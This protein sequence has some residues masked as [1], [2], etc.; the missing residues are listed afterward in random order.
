V[1]WFGVDQYVYTAFGDFGGIYAAEPT[2]STSSHI[3]YWQSNSIRFHYPAEHT[4]NN[5]Q[6]QLEMQ[7]FTTDLYGRHLLCYSNKAAF[8]IIFELVPDAPDNPFFAWIDDIN[9]PQN[10]YIDPSLLISRVAGTTTSVTGYSGTDSM[11]SCENG[12]CWYVFN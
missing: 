9:A 1:T 10:A 4:L 2:K 3:V 8:S 5:T 12:V 11:P 6:Y 7:I